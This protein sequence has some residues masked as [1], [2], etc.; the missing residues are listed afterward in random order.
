MYFI[1]PAIFM[2][3]TPD[4]AVRELGVKILR[5][6]MLAEPMF[7]VSIVAAAVLR[8]AGDTLIPSILNAISIWGIRISLCLIL[9]PTYGLKGAWIAMCIEL[10]CRG[11]LLLIRY[12]YSPWK[13]QAQKIAA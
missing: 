11:T 7:G 2:I 12:L 6:E 9:V 8:G 3:F 10:C 5:I 13:K 4:H 1:C